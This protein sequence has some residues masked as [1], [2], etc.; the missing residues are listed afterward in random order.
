MSAQTVSTCVVCGAMTD[1]FLCG[2]ARRETGCLGLLLQRLGDCAWL[3]EQLDTTLARQD[4]VSAG[5]VGFVTGNAEKPLPLNLG[6]SDASASLRDKLC[7]W[8]RCLWEDNTS[9]APH[10]SLCHVEQRHHAEGPQ[11]MEREWY[12]ALPAVEVTIDIVSTSR[13]LMRHPTWI[14]IHPAVDELFAELSDAIHSAFRAVDIPKD[15]RIFLGKC[16]FEM[17]DEWCQ[18]E[19]Y[20]RPRATEVV[21]Q[22]C[23][24]EW[25]VEER[26]AHL[27]S[28]AE[29]EVLQI[30]ALSRLL[31]S[32]GVE[33]ATE[34]A[35][36][37]KAQGGVIKAV[38]KAAH[39]RSW[40]R[41]G[42]VMD[43]FM[44][45]EEPVAA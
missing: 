31:A 24:S 5:S 20:S 33:V 21:C 25:V 40:F 19:L 12:D 34:K 22:V 11:R 28:V 26:L 30:P 3:A 41:V 1:A 7:S 37:A 23:G 44:K 32:L 35:I 8:V 13:W 36:R 17:N 42:D 38:E 9:L 6:A 2:D 18:F 39:G 45:A 43:A 14:A 16:G 4:K 27:R 15:T 29:D 10:C